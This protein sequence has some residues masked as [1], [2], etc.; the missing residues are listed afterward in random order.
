MFNH[1]KCYIGFSFNFLWN[2]YI[3]F[4]YHWF[5]SMKINDWPFCEED[6]SWGSPEGFSAAEDVS[7]CTLVSSTLSTNKP[8]LVFKEARNVPCSTEDSR[9]PIRCSDVVPSNTRTVY[10]TLTPDSKDRLF[11]L[12]KSSSTDTSC[13]SSIAA[14]VFVK[15]L[16]KECVVVCVWV[17]PLIF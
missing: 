2:W 6:L 15:A 1:D 4:V 16:R 8:L 3:S 11:W 5:S 10:V 13:T 17:R 9:R 14:I 7:S 12:I